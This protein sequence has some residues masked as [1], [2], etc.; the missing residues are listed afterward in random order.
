MMGPAVRNTYNTP[1]ITNIPIRRRNAWGHTSTS[2]LDSLDSIS[3]ATTPRVTRSITEPREYRS[4][5]DCRIYYI[6][7][8]TPP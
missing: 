1:I 5:N 7:D 4:N 8:T 6:S 2:T 3:R